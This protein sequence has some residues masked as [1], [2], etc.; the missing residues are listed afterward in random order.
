LAM[1]RAPFIAYVDESGDPGM[2]NFDPSFPI[3]VLCV[4]LY[5][6]E[7][8]LTQDLAALSRLKFQH[9]WHDAV[10]FHSHKIRNKLPPFQALADPESA[11]SFMS[12]VGVFF[13]NSKATIIAAAI[14]KPRHKK[15]YKDPDHP[16]NMALQFCLERVFGE[17][18]SRLKPEEIVT[19]VFE[20][21]GRTEDALLA[22]KFSEYA[23]Y[24]AWG[25]ALP[26][27]ARFAA[28]EENITGLQVADLAAYP[29][30]R[31]VETGDPNRKDWLSVRPRIRTG[32]GG[33]IEGYGLKIFP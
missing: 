17:I 26:F 19:F 22:T 6:I 21:R 33:K 14:D 16:Y 13:E 4:A 10:I 28:K 25:Q 31:F 18:R 30:A 32:P 29:I 20:K 24:N 7:D 5:T 1:S 12:N 27:R 23:K 15:Q 3:F 9:W 2:E 11:K 8:Y